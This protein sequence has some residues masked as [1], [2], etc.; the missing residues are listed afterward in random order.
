[1]EF[2]E[3][4]IEPLVVGGC[5]ERLFVKFPV[6]YKEVLVKLREALPFLNV[7][8]IFFHFINILL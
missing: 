1:M 4:G 5:L 6:N 8:K 2:P 7:T 3:A